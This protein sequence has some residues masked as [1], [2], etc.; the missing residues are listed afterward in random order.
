MET[1]ATI[2]ARRSQA[3]GRLGEQMAVNHLIKSGFEILERNLRVGHK[4]IDIIARHDNM[5]VCVE[6]KTRS[7]RARRSGAWDIDRK[8]IINVT[9]AGFQ[10]SF[11]HGKLP[12]RF[13]AVI[14]QENHNGEYE[15]EHVKGAFTAPYMHY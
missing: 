9:S 8:K 15:L 14:C 4:E 5:L 3:L 13:D 2:K 12:V 1:R 11:A 7:L 10:Y 6:V